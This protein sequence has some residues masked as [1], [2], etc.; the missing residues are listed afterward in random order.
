MPAERIRLAHDRRLRHR[1]VLQD[2][3]LD[4]EGTDPVARALDDVVGAALEPEI[5]VGVAPRQITAGQPPAPV[6]LTIP[7]RVVPV[8]E[9]VVALR[10]RH[11][12]DVADHVR[13]HLAPLVV[14]H[15]HRCPRH[16]QAHG[17]RLH[18]HPHRAQVADG[19]AELARTVL[20]HHGDAPVLAKEAHHLGVQRLAAAA[21]GSET[22][23][24]HF[25]GS[26][27]HHRA[28]QRGRRG[29]VPHPHGAQG[30]AAR[31]GRRRRLEREHRHPEG[32]R[33]H[34]AHEAVAPAGIAG[35]PEHVV[36]LE[37]RAIDQVR[38]DGHQEV[39]GDLHALRRPGR[40]RGVEQ[41]RRLVTPAA[42]RIGPAGLALH[43]APEVHVSRQ[44]RVVTA[45]RDR[46]H[47]V[48]QRLAHAHA[49]LVV[50]DQDAGPAVADPVLH[51]VRPEPGEDRHVD[52]PGLP[53][54][55]HRHEHLGHA[56]QEARDAV[57]RLHAPRA[58]HRREARGEGAQLLVRVRAILAPLAEPPERGAPGARVAVDDRVAEVHRLARGPAE[59][60]GAVLPAKGLPGVAIARR[61]RHRGVSIPQ[62]PA[63]CRRPRRGIHQTST[64]PPPRR[65]A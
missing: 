44:A 18:L 40:A 33:A 39:G 47:A 20:V 4:L 64:T 16:R 45:D 57:A 2:R 10:I 13:A 36:R 59:G 55:D 22:D 31:L 7:L 43:R 26:P 6:R 23:T 38:V 19:Q 63:P 62:G 56:R 52:R 34:V 21:R 25:R 37:I 3:A 42:D 41:H 8:A 65:R 35:G 14:H 17:A 27:R 11:H 24:A 51:R 50:R 60:A 53:R 30:G 58:Q 29:Q 1:L 54:A 61:A 5:A 49:V 9:R 48:R 15:R 12:A 28:Q 32:E 46:G